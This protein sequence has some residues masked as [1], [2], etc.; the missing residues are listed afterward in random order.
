MPHLF[1]KSQE[2]IASWDILRVV[3]TGFGMVFA[4]K[5]HDVK[6]TLVYIEMDVPLFKVWSV[7]F[8][9]FSFRVQRFDS[10]PSGISDAFAMAVHIDK[11][12]IQ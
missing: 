12:Q 11:Q 10:L 5:F 4:E 3:L 2:A 7:R 8:P 6:A 1:F 9:D